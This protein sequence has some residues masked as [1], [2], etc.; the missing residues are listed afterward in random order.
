MATAARHFWGIVS[1]VIDV[2]RLYRDSG[3]LDKDLPIEIAITGRD[4]KGV[5]GARFFGGADAAQDNPVVA[6]VMLP[7]GS[8][9][10]AAIPKE[11]LAR[12]PPTPGC[13]RLFILV[14]GALIM[15]PTIMTGRLIGE[16]LKNIGEL[17]RREIELQRLS[18]RLGLA[19]DTSQIGVW[20]M[21]IET[22][23]LVWDDRMNEFYG[24]PADGGPRNYAHWERVLH[25][26][27]VARAQQDFQ[28]AVAT[29][30]QLPGRVPH[31]ARQWRSA[32]HPRE[33]HGLQGCRRAGQDR[34]RQ[35][36]RHGG[37]DAEREA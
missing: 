21:N 4:A 22:D 13:C 6:D 3:L 37:R 32:P 1:A 34:R 28:R 33:R 29:N 15:V 31:A 14:A 7:S 11:R 30:G 8:W 27:D 16:R 25:P 10:I 18:R 12:H 19:L 5:R 36:G 17:K 2:D 9:Q 24:Y 35:L 20:E 23:E 26:D